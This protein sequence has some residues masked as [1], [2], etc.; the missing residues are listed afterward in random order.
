ME[1]ARGC[2]SSPITLIYRVN[3]VIMVVI[4]AGYSQVYVER[5]RPG[6]VKEVLEKQK[7]VGRLAL[8]DSILDSVKV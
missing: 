7:E 3:S 1:K 6:R 4:P 8:L 5:Q 2:Q